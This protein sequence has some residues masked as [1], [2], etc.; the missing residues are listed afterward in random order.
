M[1][2]HL[3]HGASDN[4]GPWVRLAS[5]GEWF[6]GWAQAERNGAGGRFGS[7]SAFFG[8]GRCLAGLC[9]VSHIGVGSGAGPGV[10]LRG[11]LEPAPKTREVSPK[12]AQVQAL[13]GEDAEPSF[14]LEMVNSAGSVPEAGRRPW[15]DSGCGQA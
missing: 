9:R 1:L 12:R 14:R 2:C 15:A 10:A 4:C 13:G 6:V 3:T 5:L 8:D 7:P 11:W